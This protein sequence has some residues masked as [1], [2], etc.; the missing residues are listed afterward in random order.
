MKTAS[1]ILIS[2]LSVGVLLGGGILIYNLNQNK[3]PTV[4]QSSLYIGIPKK[5][6]SYPTKLVV[7][8][9]SSS[10]SVSKEYSSD[11]LT[12]MDGQDENLVF[13]NYTADPLIPLGREDIGY[14][15][16]QSGN[17]IRIQSNCLE[18]I[19]SDYVEVDKAGIWCINCAEYDGAVAEF[20]Y[21][22]IYQ[23][24]GLS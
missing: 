12:N 13:L 5:Q 22:P 9:K 16:S 10:G 17:S 8:V 19:Y 7:T 23:K 11:D 4:C 15:L 3:D 6:D 1:K 18:L 14:W 2:C 21:S 20:S 24:G